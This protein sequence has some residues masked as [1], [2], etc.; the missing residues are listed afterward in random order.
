VGTL[1]HIVQQPFPSFGETLQND[2]DFPE[3]DRYLRAMFEV[4]ALRAVQTTLRQALRQA[5]D[6][7][8][9]SAEVLVSVY[10]HSSTVYSSSTSL[11]RWL[12]LAQSHRVSLLIGLNERERLDEGGKELRENLLAEH[13]L[14]R[15][16]AKPLF[17]CPE[18][19]ANHLAPYAG[20]WNLPCPLTE[21]AGAPDDT[22]LARLPDGNGQ[23]FTAT[24]RVR[25]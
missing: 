21:L 20:G 16:E 25:T 8:Q 7:A 9:D 10:L 22:A 14:H 15:V 17:H 4:V 19:L 1:N 12:N 5:Q 3:N 6:T 23:W 18:V 13:L 24:L 2:R 11:D